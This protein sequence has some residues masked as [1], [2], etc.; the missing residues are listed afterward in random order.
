MFEKLFARRGLSLDRLRVLCEV[1]EAG[2][3]AKA[4]PNDPTRQSQ[5]SRQLKELEDFFEVELTRRQGKGLCLTK[6][7]EEL[8][9]NAR[10]LLQGLQDLQLRWTDQPPTF[11][12]GAG[13]SLLAWLLL[14]NLG[15][16]AKNM[17]A[18]NFKMCNLRT[19]EIVAGLQDL[20]LDFGL[21]RKGAAPSTLATYPIGKIQY[22]L[23]CPKELLKKGT[24][25]DFDSVFEQVP[26]ALLNGD[27]EFI[28]DLKAWVEKG[29][30]SI[31]VKLECESFSQACNAV[32][33]GQYAAILP[34]LAARDLPPEKFV[35]L[36]LPF[37]KGA[38]A[39][40]LAWNPRTLRLR[41]SAPKVADFLKDLLRF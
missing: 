13:E 29:R 28:R 18:A 37:M 26:L 40:C 4:A 11:S 34:T 35:Q 19:A 38:R 16:A 39:I 6:A 32:R 22:A 33:T 2:G 36:P 5:F 23:Y 12:I 41:A 24:K 14:P 8:A 27:G 20:S 30:I 7:G 3:L 15:V 21:V 17:P 25:S 1:A 10:G 31:L 9:L